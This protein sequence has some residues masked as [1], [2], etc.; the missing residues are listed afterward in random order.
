MRRAACTLATLCVASLIGAAA[1]AAT[2]TLAT[3]NFDGDRNFLRYLDTDPLAL[4]GVNEIFG[5]AGQITDI[6]YDASGTL[7]AIDFGNLYVVDESTG[8][9]TA[10]GGFGVGGQ[11]LNAL[12]F[13]DAGTLYAASGTSGNLY[14]LDPTTGAATLAGSLPGGV[15]SSGDLAFDDAGALWGVGNPFSFAL[16]DR[17]LLLEP[18]ATGTDV[19]DIGRSQVHGL[20]FADGTLYGIGPALY[21]LDRSDGSVINETSTGAA[22]VEGAAVRPAPEPG[23]AALLLSGVAWL[24][25]GRAA[26][27]R[28]SG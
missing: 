14:T 5:M 28:R 18:G 23:I 19:G 26:R 17:L 20:V 25:T 22:F 9:A 8:V 10:I 27:G 11:S 24:L 21:E 6:A 7:Y 3:R 1:S 16:D 4:S 2:I 13:D 12:T 15:T